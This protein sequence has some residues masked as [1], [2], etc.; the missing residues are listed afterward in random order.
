[1]A[2]AQKKK[3]TGGRKP[4]KQV[5]NH[6]IHRIRLKQ[7]PCGIYSSLVLITMK[8]LRLSQLLKLL[9]LSY[10]LLLL[11]SYII[12]VQLLIS[13]THT[14]SSQHIQHVKLHIPGDLNDSRL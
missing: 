10:I 13:L 12:A 7:L 4:K 11:A 5:N 6:T 9:L 3:K 1:M 14:H 8:L 2:S